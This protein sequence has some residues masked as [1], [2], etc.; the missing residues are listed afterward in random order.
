MPKYVVSSTL[1]DP[2][3]N[4]THVISGDLVRAV[5]ELKQSVEGDIQVPGA[6]NSSRNSWTTTWSTRSTS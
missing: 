4:N 2:E 1:T 5:T 6:S 3:W